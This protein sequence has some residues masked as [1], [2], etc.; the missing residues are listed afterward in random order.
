VAGM[1]WYKSQLPCPV[2]F[3]IWRGGRGTRCRAWG[4][5]IPVWLSSRKRRNR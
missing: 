1:K 3:S 5:R 4:E 2:R